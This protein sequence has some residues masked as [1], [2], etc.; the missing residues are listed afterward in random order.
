MVGGFCPRLIVDEVGNVAR[1]W[2]RSE[3]IVKQTVEQNVEVRR[4][5]LAESVEVRSPAMHKQN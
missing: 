3:L 5:I 4:L 2:R 1:Q